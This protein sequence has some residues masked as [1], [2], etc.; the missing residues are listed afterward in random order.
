MSGMAATSWLNSTSQEWLGEKN[1][2]DTLTQSLPHNLT[3]EMGL[4]LLD[5]ADV[6]RPHPE[7]VAFLRRVEHGDAT[8]TLP[9]GARHRGGRPDARPAFRAF[10]DEYGRRCPGEIDITRP[11][12][13]EQPAMLVSTILGNIRNH[14]PGAAKRLFEQDGSRPAEKEEEVLRRL[15]DLPDGQRK[16][17]ETKR[18][19]HRVRTFAGYREY[20][21]YDMVSRYSVYKQARLRR[22]GAPRAGPGGARDLDYVFHLRFDEFREVVKTNQAGTPG[23][24]GGGGRSSG[25]SGTSRRLGCSPRT[26]RSSPAP[27]GVTIFRPGCSPG[28]RCPPGPGRGGPASPWTWRTAYLKAGDILVTV[29]TDPSWTPLFVG[30]HGAGDGGGKGRTTTSARRSHGS[31]ACLLLWGWR[32]PPG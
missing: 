16:A 4:A 11:R 1:V 10:L 28:L 12:W 18:M 24:S 14:E 13:R 32:T 23:S 15:R 26:G 9:R 8:T 6:M 7:V 21:E 25:P 29:D 22:G 19:I 30:D 20:P 31:T 5:V 27:T 17:D 2:A 3:S